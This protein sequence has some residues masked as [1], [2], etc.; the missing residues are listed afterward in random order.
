[1]EKMEKL[2]E[3]LLQNP[4][5]DKTPGLHAILMDTYA[6]HDRLD[7]ALQQFQ[8]VKDLEKDEFEL[9]EIKIVRLAG[10]LVKNGKVDDAV[11]LLQGL[12]CNVLE[13]DEFIIAVNDEIYRNA[14]R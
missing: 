10:L 5:F 7:E 9:D 14:K 13:V 1:M 12:F 2:V 11:K 3:Q 6:A 8:I 4:N